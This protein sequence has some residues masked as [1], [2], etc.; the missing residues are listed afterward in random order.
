M[1]PV[2]KLQAA[3]ANDKFVI[4]SEIVPPAGVITSTFAENAHR[5]NDFVHAIN[6][7]A[8]PIATARMSSM[9]CCK[10]L[11]DMG[12]EPILQITARDQNRLNLQSEV[13]GATSRNIQNILCLTGDAPTA[14]RAPFQGLPFDLDS[15]QMLWILRRLRDEGRFLDRRE[16]IFRPQL[17]LGAAGSPNDPNPVHEALRI[18]KKVNA[19]AQFIQT[20]LDYEL[21]NLE[22]WLEALDTRGLLLKVYIL[23]GIAPLRS[24]DH[25]HYIREHIPDVT[26]PSNV[27]E[28]LERSSNLESTG[29]EIARELIKKVRG[30]PGVSGVHLISSNAHAFLTQLF[31]DASLDFK[32]PS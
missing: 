23:I 21:S 22:R 10:L 7:A 24:L 30:L 28:M 32:T 9:A 31:E 2:S 6:I 19:G 5:L 20:Q 14:G 18:E 27:I 12:I 26:I 8:Y 1:K 15:T 25:A 3:L 11:K 29:F 13:L 17:F 4:T 16:V